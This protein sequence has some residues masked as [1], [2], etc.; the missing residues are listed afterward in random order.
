MFLTSH[1]SFSLWYLEVHQMKAASGLQSE[2]A[3]ILFKAAQK[4]DIPELQRLKKI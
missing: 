4:S 1:I 3:T 2:E